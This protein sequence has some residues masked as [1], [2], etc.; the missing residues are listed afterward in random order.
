MQF[1][2]SIPLHP[3]YEPAPEVWDRFVSAHPAA[4]ILQTAGWG[5]LKQHFEWQAMPIALADANGELRAAALTLLRTIGW[6]GIGIS[7]GYVPCG[8]LVDWQNRA[9]TNALLAAVEQRCRQQGA[10]LLKIEPDLP[11]TAANRQ[12]LASYGFQPSAQSIQPRSTTIIDIS[13]DEEA[14]LA[15]MK[16]KWRYNV[17]LSQKKGITI[18]T[19]TP[20]DLPAFNPVSYTHLSQS[21]R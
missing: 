3:I 20:A 7:L 21:T 13:G 15:S 12:L 11:D 4:H 10:A 5:K 9:E 16:Q 18:R 14:I 8:P 6:R 17:R 1:T 19:A 2:N